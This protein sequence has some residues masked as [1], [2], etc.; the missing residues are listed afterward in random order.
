M[1]LLSQ[2]ELE[3][4]KDYKYV[5]VPYTPFAK[6]INWLVW[7]RLAKHLPSSW[8]PNAITIVSSI[9]I[10]LPTLFLC[11]SSDLSL[12]IH[13]SRYLLFVYFI[14]YYIYPVLDALDGKQARN[15]K[16]SSPLGQMLDH[17]LDGSVN[18]LY[19]LLLA[20]L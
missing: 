19:V 15:L 18:T 1:A 5:S 11:F 17:G 6:I 14:G 7:E 9:S 10:V 12:T 20:R 2:Q 16:V 13:P 8:A 3:K 4:L